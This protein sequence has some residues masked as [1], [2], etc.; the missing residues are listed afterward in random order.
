M[1]YDT[2]MYRVVFG[3]FMCAN[4]VIFIVFNMTYLLSQILAKYKSW[5][6]TKLLIQKGVLIE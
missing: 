1:Q 4:Y 5:K 3:W 2:R 6:K